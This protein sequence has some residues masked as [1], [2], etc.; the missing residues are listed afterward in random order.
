[1]LEINV[2]EASRRY[3]ELAQRA[4]ETMNFLH[5]YLEYSNYMADIGSPITTGQKIAALNKYIIFDS[6]VTDADAARVEVR[7][8]K[9]EVFPSQ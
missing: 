6:A 9:I 8:A 5:K 1:M 7:G 3:G 2:K 4:I